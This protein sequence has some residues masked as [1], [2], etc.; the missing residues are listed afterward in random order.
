MVM[1][2]RK[3]YQRGN[4]QLH[5]GVWTLRY[6]ELNH[7]TCKWFVKREKLGTF[8]S[9]KEARRAAEPI[10]A[11]VN[12]RNN[13]DKPPEIQHLTFRQFVEGRWKAYAVST[14]HQPSTM[15][16]YGSLLKTHLLPH[17][18]NRQL[19]EILP[20]DIS[21]LL[22]G[23]QAKKLSANT[24][25]SI[26]SLLR[27]MFELA[28]E[29]DLIERSPVRPKLHRPETAKVEKPTLNAQSIRAILAAMQDGQERLFTLIVALTGIRLEEGLA[30]RWMDFE[31]AT[32]ELQINHT[33]YRNQLKQPKT[34]SSRRAIRLVPA[35]AGVLAAYR[36]Q[37]AFQATTDFIFCRPDGNPL[38]PRTI[39][40]HLYKAMDRAEIPRVSNKY[41]FHIFRHTAGT[42]M[43]IKS[44]DLK[45][46]QGA[47]GH[48]NISTTSNI[49]VH[50]DDATMAEGTELLA[51]EILGKESATCDLFVTKKRKLV[52]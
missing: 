5:N 16:C 1:A 33:L 7:A 41:G 11:R 2:R 26:Y 29:Y 22:E 23:L 14:R 12:E 27:L 34:E 38:N 32:C 44:R 8:K 20:T 39:R 6:R 18:G 13:S 31:A 42:L 36:E 45:L 21:D 30:L 4:V 10:M 37:S 9:K 25:Q 28:C 47:L 40:R 51:K 35:I 50:L 15:D 17:F 48:S 3:T 49:Y 52:G 24:L 46:V 43:Y 19:R